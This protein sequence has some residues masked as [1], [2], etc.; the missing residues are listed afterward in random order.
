MGDLKLD[1]AP[2]VDLRPGR[3]ATVERPVDRSPYREIELGEGMS[4]LRAPDAGGTGRE[5]YLWTR[6]LEFPKEF[7][8]LMDA[9]KLPDGVQ[10]KKESLTA[11]E[12]GDILYCV[13][14]L[15]LPPVLAV[16]L[17]MNGSKHLVGDFKVP[18]A[19]SP[20]TI[21][22]GLIGEPN[23]GK[24]TTALV[25]AERGGFPLI[26]L[27]EISDINAEDYAR[28]A[29]ERGGIGDLS[30]AQVLEKLG[31]LRESAR[32]EKKEQKKSIYDALERMLAIFVN[33]DRPHVVIVDVPGSPPVL[34]NSATGKVAGFARKSDAFDWFAIMGL[35]GVWG[36]GRRMDP[37]YMDR[38]GISH[39]L[40]HFIPQSIEAARLTKE[41]LVRAMR[42]GRDG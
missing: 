38:F 7:A 39:F 2:G 1:H 23:I 42:M 17:A 10:V 11:K 3:R 18:E 35:D 6:E 22:F 14:T 31:G 32:R 29:A 37:E 27:D 24:S 21:L 26:S 34:R 15:K 12:A 5:L 4:I 41:E 8:W 30:Y 40:K 20:Q 25:V 33:G 16:H 9:M 36:G 19:N 28:L 13:E